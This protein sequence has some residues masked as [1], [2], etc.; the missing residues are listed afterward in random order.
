MAEE[1]DS[2]TLLE[3]TYTSFGKLMLFGEYLVLR[4]TKCSAFPLSKG[5]NLEVYSYS[6]EGVLWKSFEFDQCWLEI[7]FSKEL[8]ILET[9]DIKKATIIQKLL[10]LIVQKESN[11][12]LNQLYL[13]FN[14]NFNRVY[15]FGTSSTLI[16]LLSQWSGVDA[17][18]LLEH[19]FKGSGYDIAVATSQNPIVYS[20]KNKIESHFSLHQNITDN[21]LFVYLGNKQNSNHEIVA[22]KEKEV[23]FQQIEEMNVIVESATQCSQIEEWEVLMEKSEQLLSSILEM[24]K[25]KSQH[26]SDYPYA[27]KSLGAWGGDFIMVTCRNIIESK[28]YF[29]QKDKIPVYTFNELIK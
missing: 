21:L 25:V 8:V 15:G 6:K 11:L 29:Q 18:V 20:V 22:F 10:R 13:K 19:S 23:S 3:A 26:F 4:G 28:K 1:I 12:V 9:T 24:P 16:S 5:Q 27:I 7:R 14:L 17:Y 2:T